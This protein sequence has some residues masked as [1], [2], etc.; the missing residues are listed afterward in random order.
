MQALTKMRNPNDCISPLGWIFIT[1]FSYIP[2]MVLLRPS[3]TEFVVLLLVDMILILQLN[4]IFEGKIFTHLFP[5]TLEYF[6]HFDTDKIAALQPEDK[7]VAFLHSV[8]SFP[9]R[10]ARWCY[11]WAWV[12]VLPAILI[13]TV[14]WQYDRPWW[15]QLLIC[16]TFINFNLMY[17]GGSVYLHSHA[18]LTEKIL[19]IHRLKDW[20]TAFSQIPIYYSRKEFLFQEAVSLFSLIFFILPNQAVIILSQANESSSYVA[21]LVSGCGVI[22]MILFL[23]NWRMSRKIVLGGL[24]EIFT[25]ISTT[26]Y[27][28]LMQTLPISTFPMLGKF[29]QSFNELVEKIRRSENELFSLVSD[30]SERSR[31]RTLG[32]ISGL[33]A[34]DL[35]SPL[36]VIQFCVDQAFENSHLLEQPEYRR[37]LRSNIDRSISLVNS[38]RAKVRNVDTDTGTT[39]FV[40]AHRQ[41]LEVLH[42]HYRN[43]LMAKLKINLDPKLEKLT[44]SI[45][46]I[47]LIQI[48]DNLYSNSLKDFDSNSNPS[49]E[50]SANLLSS[51]NQYA[52]IALHDNG[53]GLRTEDFERWTALGISRSSKSE[54][55]RGLGLRLTR[56]LTEFYGGS[57]SIQSNMEKGTTLLLKLPLSYVMRHEDK[58]AVSI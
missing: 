33:I 40:D 36:H 9:K 32:E 12:K 26:H 11:S 27:R 31:F 30:Y 25:I 41:T 13:M 53:S 4:K 39:S 56:R 2:A 7:R 52:I 58:Q 50:I 17:F 42:T 57:L 46:R 3:F 28:D 35:S 18:F 55:S 45:P 29:G 44:T 48:L 20:S 5:D 24:E 16:L 1:L 19:E 54:K 10:R 21:L 15:H 14:F 49:P 43:Q 34:H 22:G 6:Y 38:L 47:D 8:M 23:D 51:E 37:R